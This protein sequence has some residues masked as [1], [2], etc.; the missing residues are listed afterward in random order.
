MQA[1]TCEPVYEHLAHAV[2]S[3]DQHGSPWEIE[4]FVEGFRE[5]VGSLKVSSYV[6]NIDLA[7]IVELAHEVD[8]AVTSHDH[9]HH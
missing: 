3:F 9:T 6:L 8:V 1:A 5:S 7:E 2:K 4:E